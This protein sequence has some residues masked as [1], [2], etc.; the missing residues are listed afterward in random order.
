MTT[1]ITELTGQLSDAERRTRF[2]AASALVGQILADSPAVPT[3]YSVSVSQWVIGKTEVSFYFHH[4]SAALARF[5]E[6]FLMSVSEEDRGEGGLY[7]EARKQVRDVTVKAW[8]LF[9]AGAS[10]VAA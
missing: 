7:K 2:L 6:E 8:T 3:D 4:D 1:Q 5:A 9:P 10:E